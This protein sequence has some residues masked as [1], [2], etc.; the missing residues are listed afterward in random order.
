M[1]LFV[2]ER[3]ATIDEGPCAIGQLHWAEARALHIQSRKQDGHMQIGERNEPG[4]SVS[5]TPT[6]HSA[7]LRR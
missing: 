7:M 4:S 2:P 6:A 3:A 5:S 1:P